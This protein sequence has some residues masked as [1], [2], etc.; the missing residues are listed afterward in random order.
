[1]LCQGDDVYIYNFMEGEMGKK[2]NKGRWSTEI[3]D[4]EPV[5][6]LI[7][8]RVNRL[9]AFWKWMPVSMAMPKMLVE[10]MK[11][12]ELGLRGARTYLSGREVL[13]VQYWESVEKLNAYARASEHLHLPA[14]KAFNKAV[15]DSGVVGIWHETYRITPGTFEGVYANMP[16]FGLAHAMGGPVPASQIGQSAAKRMRRETPD[17]PALE[18]Y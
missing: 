17:E 7:G 11:N 2:I 13:L 15:R 16:S 3:G 1:M 14:W 9:W 10:L 5:V 8:M 6:F 18:P 4:S 12:K